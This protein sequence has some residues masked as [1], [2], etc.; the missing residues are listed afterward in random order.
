MKLIPAY[1]EAGVPVFGICRGIQEMN[2][3]LG[4]TLH[5]RVHLVEGKL[6]HRLQRRDDMT[7]ED[8]F[9][10]RHDVDLQGSGLFSRLTEGAAR[11][12]VNSLH[13]QGIDR[14][15]SELQVEAISEDGLIEGVRLGNGGP[16]CGGVQ[17]HAEFAPQNHALSDAIYKEF[18]RAVT[19]HAERR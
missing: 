10:L 2:V 5:Y 15:A 8:V 12:R 13:G 14:L 3:A 11:V 9:A 17:G 4:G 7:T 16:F 6:D 1:L 18:A 19:A